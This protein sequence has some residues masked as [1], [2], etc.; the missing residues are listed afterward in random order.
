MIGMAFAR[1]LEAVA[2][3]HGRL[4]N[5]SSIARDRGVISKTVSGYSQILQETLLG[6]TLDPWRKKSSRH[7]IETAKFESSRI[8]FEMAMR[9]VPGARARGIGEVGQRQELTVRSW[10]T[11]D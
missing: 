3:I 1:L 9:L 6:Q 2:A 5:Y 11:A 10:H 7:L 4:I 8:G